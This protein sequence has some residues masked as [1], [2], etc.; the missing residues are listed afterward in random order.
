[1]DWSLSWLPVGVKS[2]INRGPDDLQPDF[3]PSPPLHWTPQRCHAVS[4]SAKRR[5][6]DKKHRRSTLVLPHP[7]PRPED[8]WSTAFIGVHRAAAS[9]GEFPSPPHPHRTLFWRVWTFG[10]PPL[11]VSV[12]LHPRCCR[13]L[14]FSAVMSEQPPRAIH[15]QSNGCDYKSEYPF[16]LIKSQ[17]SI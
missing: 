4:K 8:H 11:P 1:M 3:S 7:S 9:I 16:D 12:G 5:C 2:P 14:L 17:P 6:Q 13:P 15:H 10:T